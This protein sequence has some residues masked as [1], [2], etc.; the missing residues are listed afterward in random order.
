[1]DACYN[2]DEPLNMMLSHRSESETTQDSSSIYTQRKYICGSLGLE[3][4]DNWGGG[5]RL[6]SWGDENVLEF[7]P[8]YTTF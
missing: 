6:S 3:A 1:M 7:G 4:G 2:L 8:G 5:N